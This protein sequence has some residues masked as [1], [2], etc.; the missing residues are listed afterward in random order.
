MEFKNSDPGKWR[1]ENET[2]PWYWFAYKLIPKKNG[3]K[4]LDLGSGNGEFAL[5][6]KED[7]KKVFCTDNS[8]IYIKKLR[9][10][11]F[12]VVLADFNRNLPFKDMSFEGACCLEVIEHIVYAEKFLKEIHRILHKEGWLVIS[13]PNYSWFGY[14]FLSL[15]GKPPFKEGYHLRYFNYFSF[16]MKLEEAGFKIM[17][18]A[19]F[20]PLPFIN[21]IKQFWLPTNFWTSLFAQDLVFLCSK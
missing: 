13:T 15:I 9:K 3:E 1:K 14:R 19:C 4:V 10:M 20:T 16:K 21:R 18:Q 5:F 17:G 7:K 8:P 2:R 12:R 11:G 6:L